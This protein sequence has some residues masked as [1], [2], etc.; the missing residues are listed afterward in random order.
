MTRRAFVV[1]GHPGR[2]SFN[3]QIARTV[4]D[5]WNEVGFDVAFHDLVAEGFDPR[6]TAGEAL[7]EPTR[8]PLV[9]RHIDEFCASEIVAVVHPNCW[10]APPAIMK[11]WIDRVLAENSAYAFEKGTGHG[12]MPRG[13]LRIRAALVF[14][15]GNTP[16]DREADHF[17]D[18]LERIWTRCIFNFC[19]VED[20]RRRLFGVVATSTAAQRQDWLAVVA[21]MARDAAASRVEY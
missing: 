7:G 5:V 13:I 14:N 3:H 20:V 6:L 10:G 15:T 8:D 21:K 16:L 4:R 2:L 12:D 11:G 9:Q 19:G 1:V 17:G 18:P